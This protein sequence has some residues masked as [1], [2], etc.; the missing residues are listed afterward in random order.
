MITVKSFIKRTDTLSRKIVKFQ[1][2]HNTFGVSQK[3][4][5]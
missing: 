5:I 2:E 4:Q 1:N 3:L